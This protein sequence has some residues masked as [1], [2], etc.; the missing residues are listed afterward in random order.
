MFIILAHLLVI[1]V[2]GQEKMVNG[3]VSDPDGRALE[4]VSVL[5]K[6]KAGGIVTDASGKFSIKADG[7]DLLLFSAVG[8][9]AQELRVT[10]DSFYTVVLLPENAVLNE[11]VVTALGIR[12]N[13]NTLPYAAQ[14]ITGDD[15]NKTVTL[16][17]VSNLSGK[18][19]GLQITQAN[20][21]GGATNVILRGIKSLTQ[22]NQAM[23]VVDGVPYDNTDKSLRSYDLG[24]T[25]SDLNPDDI[26]S[27][28]VLKGAAA[29][30]LYGSRA[31]NGVIMI[32]TKK[33]AKKNGNQVSA[34][35]GITMGK[36]DNSTLPVYQTEYGQGYGSAGYDDDYPDNDGFFYYVPALFSNGQRLMV[37]QT[38]NDA[39]LGPAYDPN[40]LVYNWDAFTPGN[41]NYGKATPWM[42]AAHNRPQDYFETPVTTT[43]S[44]QVNNSGENG[45][46][47]LGYTHDDNKDFM[48]NSHLK[49]N[50]ASFSAS[51]KLMDKLMIGASIN[52]ADIGATNRYLFPY[53]GGTSPMTDFRQWWPTNIDI[54]QQ[55]ADYF[56]TKTNA[57]WNWQAFDY[58][59]NKSGSIGQPA[60]HDNLYW[61]AYQNPQNDSR[62]R[63]F[64]NIQINYAIN[65][66]LTATA[67]VSKDFYSQQ[68]ETRNDVGSQTTPF[69]HRYDEK[70][71]ET[72]Y[73]LILNFDKKLGDDINLKAVLGG[74]V[75]QTKS[76]NMSAITSGGLVVPGF[77]AISNSLKTPAAPVEYVGRKEV[78]GIYGGVTVGYKELLT[79]DGTLRRDQ[80]S[81]LPAKNNSYNYPSLSLNFQ[82]SKLLPQLPW[83]TSA[84][85]WGN[86]A[87]VGGDAPL[88]SV[89]NTYISRVPFNSQTLFSTSYTNNNP[90]LV[91]E[92]QKGWEVGLEAAFFNDR[93][94]FSATY[95]KT[96]QVDQIMPVS[97][98][99]STGYS[100]FFV[101]GGAIQN[102][103]VEISFNGTPVR[104]TNFKW[105][106]NVNWSANRQI[107]LSLYNDQPSYT[108]AVYQNAVR[109]TAVKG[110]PYQI[111]ATDYVYLNGQRVVDETGHYKITDNIYSDLGTPNP[112]WIGGINNTLQYKNLSFN[113]LIDVRKGGSVYSLDMDY[114]SSSGIYP[115]TAG[116]N[117]LG[118]PVRDP[119]TDDDKSGGIILP[120]VTE[121]GKPNT[122]RIDESDANNGA[123]SFGSSN[124]E[125]HR[126]FVYDASYIK[127]RE[128]AITY[129]FAAKVFTKHFDFIKGIDLSLTGRNL[130]IIHKNLPYADPEQGQASGNASMGFQNGAYPTIRTVGVLVKVKF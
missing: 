51:H 100:T 39:A 98:S 59:N 3:S 71:D 112:D 73:D 45:M 53:S 46:F 16:N 81:S 122:K 113:F 24:N 88:Y 72:N 91:P 69:Y 104:T 4:M 27:V 34:N 8:F 63:F 121:D 74:N 44:V 130:W 110:K 79:L 114:G 94:G 17:P 123:F 55:K 52:Y 111:Q 47:K 125:A 89:H 70:Y 66:Y 109:L 83:L 129:S 43:T 40:L 15:L 38:N 36:P 28:S 2:F 118:N 14:Q 9:N 80:S 54:R 37:V 115:R 119:L 126:E 128:L 107:V 92:R 42:P 25:A 116:L 124:G 76:E 57:T 87:A 65:S 86:Y 19:A 31:I 12:R 58:M 41:P 56:S 50:L 22:S 84:K 99:M 6:G 103:G 11:V 32:T 60:Y 33:G 1:S 96:K 77:F 105:N 68:L 10:A 120:G 48:P 78:D 90:N 108:V 61:F 85:A 101:N 26:E 30:A 29:S 7:G 117:D 23:F 95:Y 5:V 13:R 127:L 82:F 49:K 21:M 62:S 102:S 97:V 67:R 93:L 18:I 35:F 75:R 64:G 20:T 106:V